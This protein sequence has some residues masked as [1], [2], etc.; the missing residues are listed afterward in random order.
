[1]ETPGFVDNWVVSLKIW[2]RMVHVFKNWK[3]LFK[4]ICEN[5]CEWKNAL[6]YVKCCLKT[7]NNRL[8][9]QTKHPL[10]TQATLPAF[11]KR[12]NRQTIIYFYTFL[13]SKKSYFFILLFISPCELLWFIVSFFF[14]FN[15]LRER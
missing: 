2:G 1:M 10:I 7:K 12:T 5:M 9:T 8:K 6:K 3:L 11:Q 14:Q 15:N 4:N 13:T